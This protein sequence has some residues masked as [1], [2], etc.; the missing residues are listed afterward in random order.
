MTKDDDEKVRKFTEAKDAKKIHQQ[1]VL[2][3]QEV[4]HSNVKAATT[5]KTPLRDKY[6]EELW[7]SKPDNYQME[8][9][10]RGHHR[11]TTHIGKTGNT[12]ESRHITAESHRLCYEGKKYMSLKS[13]K[14]MPAAKVI[15]FFIFSWMF[16]LS[17]TYN[18]N[19]RMS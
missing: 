4:E 2:A 10:G 5:P 19:L 11:R 15:I 13:Y 6:L 1:E 17:K 18:H 3:D 14:I 8:K 7:A 16:M 9:I 12:N